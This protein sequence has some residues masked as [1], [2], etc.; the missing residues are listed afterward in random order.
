MGYDW[1]RTYMKKSVYIIVLFALTGITFSGCKK[2]ND[3][4]DSKEDLSYVITTYYRYETN[5]K[6]YKTTRTYDGY[7]ETGYHYYVDDQLIS[8]YKNF[9]YDGLNA[10]WDEYTYQDNIVIR[11][12]HVECEYLDETFLRTKYRKE[13]Y[14]YPDSQNND[15]IESFYEYEGKKKVSYKNYRNGILSGECHDYNYDGLRCTYTQTL[16]SSNVV[17]E[18]RSYN[19]LYLDDTYLRQKSYLRSIERYDSNGAVCYSKTTYSVYKYDGKKPKPVGGRTF[20]NGEL[21]SVIRDYQY[22]GLSCRYYV[23]SYRDGEVYSTTMCEVEYL[24]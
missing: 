11:Q 8:E 6:I 5:G 12:T 1:A 17:Y 3:E 21:S 15:I 18:E 7:K 14:Y 16:Y 13:E 4:L 9:S 19:I 2:T 10:S 20:T 24:E 23:D 22:D